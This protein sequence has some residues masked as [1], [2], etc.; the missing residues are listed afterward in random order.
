MR[1]V[2]RITKG[3]ASG[4]SPNA[5]GILPPVRSSNTTM[6][7]NPSFARVQEAVAGRI[8]GE[9]DS[10]ETTTGGRMPP[11]LEPG[12]LVNTCNSY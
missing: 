2:N 3:Q 7:R 5:G 6:L 10:D 1:S 4:S 11:A 8:I 12:S 9:F